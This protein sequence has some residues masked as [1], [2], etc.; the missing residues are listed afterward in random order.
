MRFERGGLTPLRWAVLS[1]VLFGAAVPAHAQLRTQPYV[2]GLSFPVGFIPDPT[3]PNRFFV[4][5]Q[6]GRIRVVVD[7]VLLAED[8]LDITAL[9]TPRT[10]IEAERGLL[11]MV[12]APDYATSGRFFIMFTRAGASPDERGDN[13]ISRLT[14]SPN[15]LR[16]DAASRFDLRWG[17]A[18]GPAYIEH[19]S[20]SSHNG[21]AMAFGSDGYLYIGLGDGGGNGDPDNNAQ[22]PMELKGKILR[23]DVNVPD[24]DPQGYRIPPDNPFVDSQPIAALPE[25][26]AV[27]V[28]NPWRLTFDDPALGG[29][30][31]LLIADVGQDRWEEVTYEPAGMGGRN[32]G[33]R[34]LEGTNDYFNPDVPDYAA[35]APAFLPLTNPSLEYFHSAGVSLVEGY[36]LT[37]GYIYRGQGLGPAMRGRY[38]FSD[39]GLAKI[40]SA[41]VNPQGDTAAFSDIVEHTASMMP[42]RLS[43]FAVDLNGEL[44]LVRYGATNQ[45]VVSRVCGF[46]VT[47][48]VTSFST[49]GGTGTIHVTAPPGCSWSVADVAPGVILVSNSEMTGSGIVQ[50]RMT[51]NSSGSD[52][53]LT[54]RVAGQTITLSQ[55]VTAGLRG[56]IN[57]DDRVDLLWQH[58]DGRLAAWFMDGTRMR[59]GGPL[60]AAPL[61]DP[62]WRIA[63]SGDFD[64]DASSDVIFQHGTNGR[65]VAWLMSGTVVLA[66]L[67]VGEVPET[68]W[69]IRGAADMNA[70]GW[71]DLVWQ[72]EEDGRLAVWLMHGTTLTEG[73]LIDMP[74]VPDRDWRI[75]AVADLNADGSPDFVWRNQANGVLAT[76]LMNGLQ[77][78][79]GVLLSPARVD[80]PHWKIAA[81]GDFNGDG[82]PDLIWHHHGTGMIAAW[83]MRGYQLVQGVLLTPDTVADTGWKIAGPK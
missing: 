38:F 69:K 43:S 23:I 16:A 64:G 59:E 76:W 2:T 34:I 63:A 50:F 3:A 46:T 41:Q 56:D 79:D 1:L 66:G 21:G 68:A 49:A 32:Y 60:G 10:P 57:G 11:G 5:E 37:G 7:G 18:A 28:R 73:R 14:W 58:A 71:L 25:I 44:Y 62:A 72:H 39:F 78:L 74:L 51:G 27:G 81:A 82:S 55:R 8:F 53:E 75:V 36:S 52:R 31:A 80:D 19:S 33:W 24:D 9:V 15:P 54:L 26:W 83:L 77:Y 42:G 29:T 65:I 70:D 30:G 22:N 40:W 4:V 12:L 67:D 6:M 45:G 35:P 48:I 13:V 17:S 61:S 20:R 47:P